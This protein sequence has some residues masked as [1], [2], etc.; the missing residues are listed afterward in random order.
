[1]AT[2]LADLAASALVSWIKT[3]STPAFL[4]MAWPKIRTRTRLCPAW[5]SPIHSGLRPTWV[6]AGAG[7]ATRSR[8][9]P[10]GRGGVQGVPRSGTVAVMAAGQTEAGAWNGLIADRS[11]RCDGGGARCPGTMWSRRGEGA[12]PRGAALAEAEAETKADPTRASAA[13][14]ARALRAWALVRR[15]R[16]ESRITHRSKGRWAREAGHGSHCRVDG[17]AT[18]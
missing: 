15:S 3:P 13:R 6:M 4:A 8:R 18:A 1:M 12:C 14:S 10:R 17:S 5:L 11:G 7:G 9:R 2:G 16:F